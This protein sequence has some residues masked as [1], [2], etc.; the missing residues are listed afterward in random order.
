LKIGNCNL[1]HLYLAPRWGWSRW[2]FAGDL[3]LEFRR[4]SLASEN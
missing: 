1:T 2:N 4:R 3:S